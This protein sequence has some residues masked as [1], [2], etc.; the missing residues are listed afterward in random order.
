M[1]L[2]I[3]ALLGYRFSRRIADLADQRLCRATLPGQAPGDYGAP[4]DVARHKIRLEKITAHWDDGTRAAASLATG[5]VR[6]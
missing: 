3:F 1:V 6:A 5:T 4:N 2:G